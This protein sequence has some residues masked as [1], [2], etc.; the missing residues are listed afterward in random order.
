MH[1]AYVDEKRVSNHLM[2]DCRTYLK[3]QEAIGSKQVG[4]PGSIAYGAPPP[5]PS[6]PS[7]GDAATQGQ[8]NLGNQGN[9]DTSNQK[10]T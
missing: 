2:R 3:L 5:P 9:G 8:S 4:T 10:A 1:Y 7:H 6:L